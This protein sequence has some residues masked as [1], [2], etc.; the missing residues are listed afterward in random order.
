PSSVDSGHPG[1]EVGSP[2][3][4][5]DLGEVVHEAVGDDQCGTAIESAWSWLRSSSVSRAGCLV[6][7]PVACRV[8]GPTGGK[9]S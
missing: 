1:G 5:D 4:G 3:L 9:G 2:E 7:Q 6:S 8:L